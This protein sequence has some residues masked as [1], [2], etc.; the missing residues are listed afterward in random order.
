[1]HSRRI[2][3][4]SFFCLIGVAPLFSAGLAEHVVVVVW[5]GLRPDFVNEEN[6][7]TLYKLSQQGVFFPKHHAVYPSSTE[8]NGAAMATGAYPNHTGIVGNREYR[9]DINPQKEF[10]TEELEFV[11]KGDSLREG[12]YLG[13]PTIAETLQKAGFGTAVAGTKGVALFQDRGVERRSQGAKASINVF[14][15]KTLPP[16]ALKSIVD[17]LRAFPKVDFPNIKQDEWTTRALTESLWKAGVPKFSLLW[18]SE[19]DYTQ[20]H[21]APGSPDA[22]TALK[23]SDQ[24]LATVLRTLERKTVRDKTDIFVVSDHG[25]STI[26]TRLDIVKLL[27][28]A[29][30]KGVRENPAAGDI[31][32]VGNGGS[33]L[34]YVI[35]H[36]AATIK[37]LV[38]FLQASDFAGVIFTREPQPGCFRTRVAKINSPDA[39]DA[40]V[41]MRWSNQTNKFGVAGTIASY[42]PNRGMDHRFRVKGMGHHASM[43]YFDMHNT[44]IAAGP[45]FRVGVQSKLPSGNVDLAPTILHILGENPSQDLDGRILSEALKDSA[46]EQPD[47][48]S[49]TLDARA[50]RPGF[51]WHQYVRVSK[52]GKTSYFDEGNGGQER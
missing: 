13:V 52:V 35:G 16:A 32:V 41:S 24:D 43:S 29:G 33:A 5:D 44:L 17:S 3:L 40:I 10:K 49:T 14:A 8:V 21:K 48:E 36:D 18:L 7:P 47:A 26:S 25:F 20:H 2:F 4:L 9:S 23:A 45:D 30:L 19:P 38:E 51:V 46:A 27:R 15:G 39:P 1:M 6:T 11:T 22:L 31:M 12:K 34:F 28:R 37:K 50:K 42:D